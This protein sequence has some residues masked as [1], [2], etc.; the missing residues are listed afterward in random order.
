MNIR[1]L[2]YTNT[3]R[4]YFNVETTGAKHN[5]KWFTSLKHQALTDRLTAHLSPIMQSIVIGFDF[6]WFIQ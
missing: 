6:N 4:C 3:H 5:N 1:F 2:L